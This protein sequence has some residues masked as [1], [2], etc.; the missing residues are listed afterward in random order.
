MIAIRYHGAGNTAVGEMFFFA[1]DGKVR[2][3]TAM[4]TGRE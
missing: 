4:Y 2:K 3:A 1:D